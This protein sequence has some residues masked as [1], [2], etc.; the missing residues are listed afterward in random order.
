M[1]HGR[2][3]LRIEPVG[4]RGRGEHHHEELVVAPPPR[5]VG[6]DGLAGGGV[7]GDERAQ[8]EVGFEEAEAGERGE[9]EPGQREAGYGPVS[10]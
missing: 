5:V 7:V 8:P 3:A 10:L 1:A 6:G 4:A 2:E 9:H